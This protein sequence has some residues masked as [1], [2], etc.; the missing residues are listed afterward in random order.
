MSLALYRKYRP[1]AFAEVVSQD[2]VKTTL[3]NAI[4]INKIGHAYIFVGAR[5]IGKTTLARLF[6][7]AINC[8]DKSGPEPCNKCEACRSIDDG[9]ALDLLEIDAASN[10]G[11]E[12]IRALREKVKF[13]PAKLKY[14]VFIIDE[15]HMLT[16]EAFNALLKTLEEPPEHAVFLLATTEV[17]KVPATILSRCQRFDLKKL[18]VPEL[19]GYLKMIAKSE[20]IE[21]SQ[22]ALELITGQADGC[23]RDAVSLFTQV[24][25]FSKG[26]I[27]QKLVK[28]VLGVVDQAAIA[29]FIDHL[30]ARSPARCVNQL[31]KLLEN[32]YDIEQFTKNLIEYLRKLMVIKIGADA[33]DIVLANLS[34]EQLGKIQAQ[35]KELA[36]AQIV[37]FIKA[38]LDAQQHLGES[39]YPQLPLEL[40]LMELFGEQ[41]EIKKGIPSN[42]PPAVAKPIQKIKAA[43]EKVASKIA[44]P[45]KSLVGETIGDKDLSSPHFSAP[46]GSASG[47]SAKQS[48]E[49]S[50]KTVAAA[51]VTSDLKLAHFKSR[52]TE[53][54]QEVMPINSSLAA[55]LRIA[56]LKEFDGEYLTLAFKF[57]FHQERIADHKYRTIVEKVIAQVHDQKVLIKCVVDDNLVRESEPVKSEEVNNVAPASS[58]VTE[59]AKSIFGGKLV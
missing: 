1:R 45:V 38:F 12:E 39:I 7:K 41:A 11:I 18:T 40:A 50:R 54:V 14:K 56:V 20:G 16:N 46:G 17:H 5:G 8:L 52:W 34:S 37:H 24:N 13:T 19:I 49:M 4:S 30:M 58:D 27:D 9:K 59:L 10:R 22:E 29:E 48:A 15:V 57:R 36:L 32:G 3:L 31:Q 21:V 26:K 47:G 23:A 28:E 2:H 25:A 43:A 51:P 42:V 35:T 33:K 44:S 53:V 55:F 6:A